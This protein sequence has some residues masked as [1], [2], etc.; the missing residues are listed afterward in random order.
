VTI[1]S[2]LLLGQI[3]DTNTGYLARVLGRI[4]VSPRYRTSVG[5][6]LDEIAQVLCAGAQRCDMI[7]T[8]GGLGPTRDDL[9]REA[10]AQAGGVS[11]EFKQELLDEIGTYFERSGYQMPRNNRRQAYVPAGSE[12]IHNPV[13]TAPCFIAAVKDKPVICL[14][15]VPRELEYLWERKVSPWI[16]ERFRL[17]RHLIAMRVLKVAGL[18]ESKVDSLIGDL[19]GEIKNPQLGLL[20]SPGE[21]K[22]RI[23]AAATDS[24]DARELILPVET[25][26]RS[27][28]GNRIFGTDDQSLEGV[29]DALLRR[30]G[31]TLAIVET[32]SAGLAAQRLY[33]ASSSQLVESRVIPERERLLRLLEGTGEYLDALPAIALAHE[34]R[35][36][37]RVDAALCIVGFPDYGKQN[38]GMSAC[39][40]ALGDGFAKEF[41]WRMGGSAHAMQERGA[42]I[43]LDTLRLA[44]LGSS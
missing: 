21:I 18:S 25:E 16:R 15:G 22:V 1:G 4:G 2:E 42:V 14:P 3:L 10:V 35:D 32:F 40:A 6:D 9:T 8:T 5:D 19:M 41:S 29:V 36:R 33:R 28:L 39:S 24:A 20:A 30:R 34:V 17:S 27:R 11:L 44:L 38:A 37:C 13:G 23:T 26:I 12:V 31:L 43:G 7:V